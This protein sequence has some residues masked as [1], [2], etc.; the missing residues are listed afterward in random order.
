MSDHYAVAGN[1]VAHSRSPFIHAAFARQTGQDLEYRRLLLPVDGFAAGAKAFFAGGGKGMN[2]TVPFKLEAHALADQLT[3]R[4]RAAGAVNT[5]MSRANGTLLGDNTD[6]AGLVRDIRSNLGW[7]IA[8]ARVLLIG[9]GG[10]ARGVMAPL[11][12]EGPSELLVVN[13]TAE[14][15]AELAALFGA[16]GPVR[17][18]APGLAEGQAFDITINASSAGL[19]GEAPV[20]PEGAIRPQTRCYDMVYGNE[21]TPFLRAAALAGAVDLAD[22]L[23]M[24]VEQ[25]AESFHLWRGVRPDTAPVVARLRGGYRIRSAQGAADVASIVRLFREYQ[26]WLGVELCFQD[27][28][29]ELASLPGAYAAPRG[30]LLL[31]ESRGEP[32]ACVA[33]RPLADDICEMKRLY[34][35]EAWRGAG[36][37][38]ALARAIIDAARTIGYTRMRLDTLERLR[39]ANLLYRDLGFRPCEPYCHNPLEGA[40]FMELDLRGDSA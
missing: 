23:G 33:L 2:V 27:F 35:R 28:E 30:A 11:L 1:P 15:A 4:A 10:A 16:E 26:E 29:A 32:I 17:G 8:G 40:V 37:G 21:P 14:R 7:V 13:R 31:A 20:L 22:G 19:S 3:P 24:L 18:G 36:L 5:L 39:A 34:I 25:A 9:A 12:A 38:R 6:G